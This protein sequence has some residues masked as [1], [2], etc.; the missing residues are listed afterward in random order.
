[1]SAPVAPLPSRLAFAD[2][3]RGM[4]ALWVVL[5]HLSEGRHLEH[6]KTLV[7]PSAWRVVF[8]WG[9]LGVPVFFVLSGF[10]MALTVGGGPFDAAAAIRFVARRMIRLTPPYY[11]AIAVALAVLLLKSTVTHAPVAWPTADGLMAHLIY[12]QGVLGQPGINSVFW[13]LCVEVQFYLAFAILMWVAQQLADWS[14]RPALIDATLVLVAWLSLLWPLGW[15]E[16]LRWM[17]SFEPYWYSFMAGVLVCRAWQRPAIGV[18]L[19]TVAYLALITLWG[20]GMAASFIF[21]VGV[22]GFLLLGA[23]LTGGMGHWLKWRPLQWLAMV[24]YS[25]Y[26]LH[27]P[28]TGM[29]SNVVHRWSSAPVLVDAMVLLTSLA[30]CCVVAWLSYRWVEV[31]SMAWSRQLAAP[32]KKTPAP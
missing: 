32:S 22:T 10:V 8:D 17:G 9:D 14:R 28:V 23:G 29:V 31:P 7:P 21:V 25:L 3:L 16:Q 30:A 27:N 2:A 11:A 26:L 24:S 19:L 12:M 1:M 6:L 13:T 18:R 5:F 15:V 20:G 4:A